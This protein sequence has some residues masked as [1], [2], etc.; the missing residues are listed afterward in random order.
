[1]PLDDSDDDKG[2]E[3]SDDDKTVLGLAM[4]IKLSWD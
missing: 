1:M 3:I 2:L 4:T